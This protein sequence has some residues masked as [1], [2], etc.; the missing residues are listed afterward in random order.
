[1]LE[2][3]AD[4]WHTVLKAYPFEMV[5]DAVTDLIGERKYWPVVADV[6]AGCEAKIMQLEFAKAQQEIERGEVRRPAPPPK[7][8]AEYDAFV[9]AVLRFVKRDAETFVDFRDA[10]VRALFGIEDILGFDTAEQAEALQA[11][12]GAQINAETGRDI[13]F[14]E[15]PPAT[16][17]VKPKWDYSKVFTKH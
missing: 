5:H 15:A 14:Q 3:M 8:T 2:L 11:K 7:E 17:W 9:S 12:Y 1:M 6:K 10:G 4:E 16:S 13:Q